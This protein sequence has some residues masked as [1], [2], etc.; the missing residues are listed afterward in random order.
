[1]P[2]VS[3]RIFSDSSCGEEL[4]RR[5]EWAKSDCDNRDI[6]PHIPEGHPCVQDVHSAG[7]LGCRSAHPAGLHAADRCSAS[8]QAACVLEKP[9]PDAAT[10]CPTRL[11]RSSSRHAPVAITWPQNGVTG[12]VC[13]QS[14]MTE[15][16]RV[17]TGRLYRV[18][19]TLF[20]A[21]LIILLSVRI[22][23]KIH[24]VRLIKLHT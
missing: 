8:P 21:N 17:E 23:R 10:W 19:Y 5:Q 11:P 6:N 18:K 13:L 14:W 7:W 4:Y 16:Y 2:S 20:T 15:Y 12:L 9:R 1:M 24:Q 22:I 3:R